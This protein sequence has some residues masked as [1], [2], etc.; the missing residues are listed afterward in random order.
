MA[1]PAPPAYQVLIL[2]QAY[3]KKCIETHEKHEEVYRDGGDTLPKI[4]GKSTLPSPSTLAIKQSGHTS[5]GRIFLHVNIYPSFKKIFDPHF[6]KWRAV[7]YVRN[8]EQTFKF[9]K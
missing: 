4:Y 7:F 2:D 3:T 8:E 5:L 1:P 6:F 9:T